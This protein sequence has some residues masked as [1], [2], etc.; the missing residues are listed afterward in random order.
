M[1]TMRSPSADPATPNPSC[2]KERGCFSCHEVLLWCIRML[3]SLRLGRVGQERRPASVGASAGARCANKRSTGRLGI[4][5]SSFSGSDIVPVKVFLV[6]DMKHLQDVISDLLASIG[7]FLLIGT[8]LPR[9]KP[10]SGWQK[11][12]AAGPGDRRSRPGAGQR[13]ERR[14]Q[15]QTPAEREQGRGLQRLCDAGIH[16]H[17]LGLGADARSPSPICTLHQVLLGHDSGKYARNENARS[18]I[19]AHAASDHLHLGP[20]QDLCLRIPGPA[21]T[22]TWKSGAARSSRC[23]GPTAPARPR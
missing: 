8:P 1:S 7:D 5:R 12:P 14:R 16:R 21:A 18:G 3:L 9:P 2:E 22:W 23:W 17:C 15:M 20:V 10:T 19:V 13:H 6:E 4:I 11:I